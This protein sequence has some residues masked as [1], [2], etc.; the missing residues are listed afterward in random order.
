VDLLVRLRELTKSARASLDAGDTEDAFAAIDELGTLLD[1]GRGSI[2][3]FV[4]ARSKLPDPATG[5][6]TGG[7]EGEMYRGLNEVLEQH[8]RLIARLREAASGVAD[9]IARMEASRRTIRAYGR[10]DV[11]P[12][13][14]ILR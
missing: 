8:S 4:A 9:E 7:M 2:E 13:L 14:S 5:G 6:A 10:P 11:P 3:A 12:T 1:E